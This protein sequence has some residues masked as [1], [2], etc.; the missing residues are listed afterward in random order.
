MKIRIKSGECPYFLTEGKVY[1]AK[2]IELRENDILFAIKDDDGDHIACVLS[3]CTFLSGGE[4]ELVNEN[5]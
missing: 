4:W 2:V 3:G 1:D 5:K